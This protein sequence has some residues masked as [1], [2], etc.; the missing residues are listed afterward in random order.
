[1]RKEEGGARPPFGRGGVNSYMTMSA[2]DKETIPESGR[3]GREATFVSS[4]DKSII[5]V[6]HGSGVGDTDSKL[7]LIEKDDEHV[8]L[9]HGR[10]GTIKVSLPGHGSNA[11]LRCA[12][13]KARSRLRKAVDESDAL[14]C[15]KRLDKLLE[16]RKERESLAFPVPDLVRTKEAR[17]IPYNSKFKELQDTVVKLATQPFVSGGTESVLDLVYVMFDQMVAMNVDPDTS[18]SVREVRDLVKYME[19]C[20]KMKEQVFGLG[21]VPVDVNVPDDTKGYLDGLMDKMSDMFESVKDGIADS[22]DKV[23]NIKVGFD[24]SF[25]T[26]AFSTFSG[27]IKEALG[28]IGDWLKTPSGTFLLHV[29]MCFG[30][31]SIL[32]KYTNLNGICIFAINIIMC[33]SFPKPAE[34][35]GR[36]CKWTWNEIIKAYDTLCGYRDDVAEVVEGAFGG[37]EE[38]K[39]GE[40]TLEFETARGSALKLILSMVLGVI[41]GTNLAWGKKQDESILETFMCTSSQFKRVK[42]G[43]EVTFDFLLDLLTSFIR[44]VGETVDS[45]YLK[46]VG[47][48]FPDIVDVS[49]ELRILM[50]GIRTGTVKYDWHTNE[51]IKSMESRLRKIIVSISGSR[52]NE[53]YRREAQVLLDEV[54]KIAELSGKAGVLGGGPR[55]EPTCVV[56]IGQSRTGKSIGAD[57]FL[58]ETIPTFL[59]RERLKLYELNRDNEIFNYHADQGDFWDGYSGQFACKIDDILQLK[60]SSTNPNPV[61]YTTINAANS[62]SLFLNMADL[63]NKGRQSFTSGMIVATDNNMKVCHNVLKSINTPEAFT[64]RWDL[65]FG[66]FPTVEFSTDET[67]DKPRYERRL[68]WTKFIDECFIPIGDT[69]FLNRPRAKTVWEYE[70]WNWATGNSLGL[71]VMDFEAMQELYIRTYNLKHKI[72]KALLNAYNEGAD[73]KI[74]ERREEL[75]RREAEGVP[76]QEQVFEDLDAFDVLGVTPETSYDAVVKAYRAKA[77]RHHPDRPNG[78]PEKMAELTWAYECLSDPARRAECVYLREAPNKGWSKDYQ[79]MKAYEIAALMTESMKTPIEPEDKIKYWSGYLDWFR[80]NEPPAYYTNTQPSPAFIK[81]FAQRVGA[82]EVEVQAFFFTHVHGENTLMHDMVQSYRDWTAQKFQAFC[83][84]VENL[85][86]KTIDFV[87]SVLTNKKFLLAAGALITVAVTA[88]AYLKRNADGAEVEQSSGSRVLRKNVQSKKSTGVKTVKKVET[89]TTMDD[90]SFDVSEGVLNMG[91]PIKR[92]LVFWSLTKEGVRRGFFVM[93]KGKMALSVS[94]AKDSMIYNAVETIWLFNYDGSWCQKVRTDMIDRVHITESLNEDDGYYYFPTLNRDFKDIRHHFAWEDSNEWKIVHQALHAVLLSPTLKK[95]KLDCGENRYVFDDTRYIPLYA[96]PYVGKYGSGPWKVGQG[97]SYKVGT[98][99]GDCGLPIIVCDERSTRPFIYGI[100]V[101]GD[102]VGLGG[103]IAVSR[104]SIEG[105]LQNFEAEYMPRMSDQTLEMDLP[106]DWEVIGQVQYQR[107]N[108]KS[109][110]RKSALHNTYAPSQ[111]RPALLH[112]KTYEEIEAIIDGIE[113]TKTVRIPTWYNARVPYGVNRRKLN[114]LLLDRIADRV[115]RS[116]LLHP[117]PGDPWEPRILTKYEVCTGIPGIMR[118]LPRNTSAGYPWNTMSKKKFEFFGRGEDYEFTSEAWNL[119]DAATDE[120]MMKLKKGECPEWIYLCFLKDELRKM[121]KVEKGLTRLVWGSPVSRSIV[122]AQLFKDWQRF[123]IDNRI[124]NGFAIGMNPM[125]VEW[126]IMFDWLLAVSDNLIDGDYKNYDGFQT[127]QLSLA[128][129]RAIEHYYYNSTSG[130]RLARETY[131]K[132]MMNPRSIC[133]T[134]NTSWIVQVH[135]A[136]PSGD[137]NTAHIDSS[138]GQILQTYCRADCLLIA[139][140]LEG[141]ADDYDEDTDFDL[142]ELDKDRCIQ[143]GDDHLMAICD[144]HAAVINQ[145]TFGDAVVRAGG[146]YTDANKTGILKEGFNN[147][148]TV[149]FLKRKHVTIPEFPGHVFAALELETILEMPQWY[150]AGAPPGVVED[151]F[152]IAIRELAAGGFERYLEWAW[153]MT[154]Q[155]RQKL[156]HV[157]EFAPINDEIGEVRRAWKVAVRSWLGMQLEYGL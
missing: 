61:V 17:D 39:M 45:D 120:D 27:K 144:E 56:F 31:N 145:K 81:M 20:G 30:M 62:N 3:N 129:N 59:D 130:E 6:E 122:C 63:A 141:G 90:Q 52:H 68:N 46:K 156:G 131:I 133:T 149:V 93:V 87:T 105:A 83:G 66:Q 32:R 104:N 9:K 2:L 154:F 5:R 123:M 40:Q 102:G 10:D 155:I 99:P 138:N 77:L 65:V 26:D 51:K 70:Q 118:G 35:F 136:M 112:N 28:S 157:S 94:H 128:S 114:Q 124:H 43:T 115:A 57:L 16:R 134:E 98:Q 33:A 79:W 100:H 21:G 135:N 23:S 18:V 103:G 7:R 121:E 76:M 95:I 86:A 4:G 54:R 148:K 143:M 71:G 92:N 84:R 111:K 107:L 97:C 88:W 146:K 153:K 137:G 29:L 37:F 152:D 117:K 42:D 8:V 72:G 101:C 15:Q 50:E 53:L 106:P 147:H 58:Y 14:V 142:A 24:F 64:N 38:A 125:S 73:E 96:T 19:C 113:F 55:I 67:K 85:C 110:L 108:S 44:F 140:G 12:I 89:P 78:T 47:V 116:W 41:F 11:T 82:T 1:M 127:E 80:T 91:N 25:I 60:D 13:T 49:D 119:L 151:T 109:K 150:E 132:D 22:A 69:F 36:A 75:D 74:R 139:N 48:R 34:T 126:K